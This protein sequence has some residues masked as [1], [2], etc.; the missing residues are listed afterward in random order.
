[1]YVYIIYIFIYM[2]DIYIIYKRY[3]YIF[4][5]VNHKSR[6]TP[7]EEDRKQTIQVSSFA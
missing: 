4:F 2:Y 6:F 5:H 1:M 3:I 7:V